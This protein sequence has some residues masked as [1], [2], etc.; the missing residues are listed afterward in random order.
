MVGEGDE[1]FFV[2]GEKFPSWFGTGCEDYFGYSWGWPTKFS[3]EYHAQPFTNGEMYG[4][5]NRL[6]NR[7]HIIDSV[8]FQSSFEAYLEKYHKDGYAN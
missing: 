5:G 8:S 3:K 4:I 2:D 6:N 7:F 1:K